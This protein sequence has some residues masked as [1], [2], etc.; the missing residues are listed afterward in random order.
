MVSPASEI[1]LPPKSK[2]S[3]SRPGSE[4]CGGNFRIPPSQ[5]TCRGAGHL[6]RAA[7]DSR[8][9]RGG[10]ASETQRP[11]SLWTLIS[12]LEAF[13][14]E[15]LILHNTSRKHHPP[16]SSWSFQSHQRQN[17]KR[18]LEFQSSLF[19]NLSTRLLRTSAHHSDGS[20]RNCLE[21]KSVTEKHPL[22]AFVLCCLYFSVND[23]DA[24]VCPDYLGLS[25][26]RWWDRKR[27]DS[28]GALLTHPRSRF[29][30]HHLLAVRPWASHQLSE[31]PSLQTSEA[32]D[33][34]KVWPTS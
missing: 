33:S 20:R 18:A 14:C 2:A 4:G 28:T 9:Q 7:S 19:Q 16:G 25:T 29:R 22:F 3:N 34:R 1:Y 31:P 15:S 5:D 11:R 21:F 8:E 23:E 13:P 10:G 30:L 27:R 32:D 26:S 17:E 24:G 12:S 6:S